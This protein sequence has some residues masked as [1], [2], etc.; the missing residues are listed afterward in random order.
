MANLKTDYK[1]DI[2][3]GNRKYQEIINADGTKSFVDVTTYE[4]D[5]DVFGGEDIN[6]TNRVINSNKIDLEDLNEKFTNIVSYTHGLFA[7]ESVSFVLP[8]NA[9]TTV[10]VVLVGAVGENGKLTSG[11]GGQILGGKGGT[12][13]VKIAEVKLN[14]QKEYDII[15]GA[16]YQGEG[17]GRSGSSTT[18]ELDGVV[19]VEAKG[20][21]P[22]S[23]ASAN[24]YGIGG[25]GGDGGIGGDGGDSRSSYTKT[26]GGPGGTGQ[27]LH[28]GKGGNPG[29]R[30]GNGGLFGNGGDGGSYREGGVIGYGGSAGLYGISG[31]F[32][33][34]TGTYSGRP[35]PKN[36]EPL[37]AHIGAWANRINFANHDP[38]FKYGKGGFSLA[39]ANRF[40]QTYI[41]GALDI[42]QA[43]AGVFIKLNT[44]SE[45]EVEIEQHL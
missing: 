44:I 20:G 15:I 35:G 28:G 22:G 3:Q 34:S 33:S 38:T 43:C 32:T 14:P 12:G 17:S 40:G 4:Q 5:G 8:K 24:G 45:S 10:F 19:I 6:A 29:G 36:K 23:N 1:D 7:Y 2:F 39:P 41:M 9:D 37:F 11:S 42:T 16:G 25:R 31:G 30:G 18:L 13:F 21:K 27:F 26:V